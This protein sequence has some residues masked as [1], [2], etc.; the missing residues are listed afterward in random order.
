M[1]G[2]II[3]KSFAIK[4]A[5]AIALIVAPIYKFLMIILFPLIVI[6]EGIIKMFSKKEFAEEIT[7]EE[8]ES[9]IDLGKNSGTLE[10]AEHQK[11]K[12]VLEFGD[13]LVE[14]IMTPRVNIE[15]ISNE[16]TV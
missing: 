14:E 11:I 5:V 8:I 16:K 1:F 12:N 9:F 6:I 15:A 7:E 10:D 2:E 4:N 3:P 13:V